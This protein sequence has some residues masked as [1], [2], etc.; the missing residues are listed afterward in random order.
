MSVMSASFFSLRSGYMIISFECMIFSFRIDGSLL[1]NV[2]LFRSGSQPYS[3]PICKVSSPVEILEAA[4][5]CCILIIR[6]HFVP[7]V[8]PPNQA[9]MM[10]EAVKAKG[11]PTALVEYEGEQHGFR[12]VSR[13]VFSAC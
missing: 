3:N 5:C 8:V 4:H 12:K 10:Y 13:S 11:I 1:L 6:R 9:R 2:W 7:Q